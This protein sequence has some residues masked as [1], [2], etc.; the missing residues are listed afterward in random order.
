MNLKFRR[1]VRFLRERG[2]QSKNKNK[3]KRNGTGIVG[4]MC[5]PTSWE[6]EPGGSDTQGHPGLH[7]EFKANLGHPKPYLKQRN[8]QTNKIYPKNTIA[9]STW[10]YEILQV[11]QE[12][13]R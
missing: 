4:Y 6:V 9:K 1:H 12:E 7:H 5:N 10:D 8:K 2:R 3:S 13:G 11:T